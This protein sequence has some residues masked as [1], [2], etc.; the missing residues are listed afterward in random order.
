MA[1]IKNRGKLSKFFFYG[2]VL[3]AL[4]H[5]LAVAGA[6]KTNT[7]KGEALEAR[8]LEYV[9]ANIPWDPDATEI[10]IDYS[11]PDIVVPK[12]EVELNFKLPVRRVRT[13]RI[14]VTVKITVNKKLAKILRLTAQV[15]HYS[16]VIKTRN[17]VNRGD[18]LTEE[19][20]VVEVIPSNRI[21]RNAMTQLDEVV[22]QQ[23]IRNMSKGRVVTA[24]S[25]HKPTL[26]K[27]GDQVTLVAEMGAMKITAP[28]IVRQKGFKDSLVKVLNIQTQ[29]TVFGMVQDEKTVKVNF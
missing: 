19:D 23:A 12:G 21:V 17:R 22:G 13:G 27:K 26:V 25:V 4:L 11:G 5:P 8:A 28:G 6:A 2:F 16:P 14:P 10:E 9:Q 18:I 3:A 20:V 15:T 1:E 7:I 24:S 29:K